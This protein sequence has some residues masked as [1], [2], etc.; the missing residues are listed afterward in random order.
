MSLVHPFFPS[1][2]IFF[3][4]VVVY[5]GIFLLCFNMYFWMVYWR[6]LLIS[7][8]SHHDT[9]TRVFHLINESC[10]QL[11]KWKR[12]LCLKRI[13]SIRIGTGHSVVAI[14]GRCSWLIFV[15]HKHIFYI[16][17]TRCNSY[18]V[19]SSSSS[20]S[21]FL[22]IIWFGMLVYVLSNLWVSVSVYGVYM[23]IY[24]MCM[25]VFVLKSTRCVCVCVCDWMVLSNQIKWNGEQQQY[26]AKYKL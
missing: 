16:Y 9:S 26:G 20:S 24:F 12:S 22:Y 14:Y 5:F 7:P 8:W 6:C 1:I 10:T 19:L 18:L 3:Y 23:Y 11:T 15:R 17:V 21:S 25:V 2:Y 4:F 13:L